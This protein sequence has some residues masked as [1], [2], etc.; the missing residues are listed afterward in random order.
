M[1]RDIEQTLAQAIGGFPWY[2]DDQANFPGATE[3]DGVCTGE[4]TVLTLA[5]MAADT[6]RSLRERLAAAERNVGHVPD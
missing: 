6:I 2:K 5:D 4:H 1:E 3:A